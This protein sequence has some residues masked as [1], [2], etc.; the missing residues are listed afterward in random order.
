MKGTMRISEFAEKV[1]LHPQTIRGMIKRGEIKPLITPSGQYRFTEEHVRQVLGI[2][3]KPKGK[4]VIYVRVSAQKQKSYLDSQI[5]VC[6]QFLA[7]KGMRIDEIITDVAS[8]FNF[9]RKGLNKL[10][11]LAFN[12]EIKTVCIYSKDRLSRIAYDL[13]EQ[14]LKRLGVEI[15]IVDNSENLTTD[16]QLKDAVEEMISFIHYITS[17]IYGS[18]SYKKKKIEKCI[19]EVIN[20]SDNKY[21]NQ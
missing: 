2:E 10:L 16:E 5:E 19:K 13:F 4:V 1:G 12:G 17:K 8:S 20:A 14:I 18:R 7:S 11:D 3:E 21:N 9:K 6:K 15:L